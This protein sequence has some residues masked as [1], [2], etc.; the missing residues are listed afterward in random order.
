MAAPPRQRWQL[1]HAGLLLVPAA[2]AAY[3]LWEGRSVRDDPAAVLAAL[4]AQSG[5]SLPS[6]AAAGA[7]SATRIERYDRERLHEVVDGAAQLYLE[8]GVQSCATA[9]YAFP[10][11]GGLE[12]VAEVYR[13]RDEAGARSRAEAERPGAA[14]PV[15]AAPGWFTDG[16]VLLG[17]AGRDLLK[18]TALSTDPRGRDRL[19]AIAAAWS[20][21]RP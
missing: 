4:R 1:V 9:R 11:A 2:A 7:G 16:Q 15:G 10:E 19:Q 5:P 14:A 3:A 12:V 20:K 17:V 21:E 13:F 18:L 6:A 8:A